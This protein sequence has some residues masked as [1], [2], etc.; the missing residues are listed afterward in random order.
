MM[1]LTG[2]SAEF[3]GLVQ[4]LAGP[5]RERLGRV[6]PEMLISGGMTLTAYREVY[7]GLTRRVSKSHDEKMAQG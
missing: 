1:I 3:E 7:L 4:R 5:G 6:G 2:L